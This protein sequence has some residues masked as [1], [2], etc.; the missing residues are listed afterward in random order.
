MFSIE[1]VVPFLIFAPRRLRHLGC[2]TLV[3]LQVVIFLTGN[4]CFFNLLTIALCLLLLD[5]AA[6]QRR[7]PSRWRTKLG[8]AKDEAEASVRVQVSAETNG[9]GAPEPRSAPVQSRSAKLR[10]WHWPKPI[11]IPLA[12]MIL[13]TSLMQFSSMAGLRWQWPAF[14]RSLYRAV[15]PLR[16][17]NSYGLF[18]VMTTNRLEIV[19][20]G[21]ND[22]EHWLEYGF[23]Y[24]PGD[25]QRRP[26]FVA[27]H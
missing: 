7:L 22:G 4:Y 5:D 1:L 25:L 2:A 15:A 11:T 20:E 8:L 21:S 24:K 26:G 14:M 3:A 23:K 10:Q 18:A 19:I 12:C 16:T 9:T 13:A 27:P 6:L 17:F